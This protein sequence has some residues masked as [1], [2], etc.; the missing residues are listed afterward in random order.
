MENAQLGAE[1]RSGDATRQ[2]AAAEELLSRSHKAAAMAVEIVGA[3]AIV[4]DN[5]REQLVGALEELG[6]PPA[7]SIV[8]LKKFLSTSG[9]D[10]NS[11][12]WAATLL[13]R[14]GADAAA[15]TD[16]LAQFASSQSELAARERCVWALGE[17]GPAAKNALPVLTKLTSAATPRIARLALQAIEQIQQ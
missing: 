9:G 4:S 14:L 8:S 3:L 15:A 10:I 11:A 5:V 16:A 6:P 2:Q 7:E 1:L 12:Y 17:I 13:G